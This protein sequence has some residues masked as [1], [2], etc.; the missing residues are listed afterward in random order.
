MYFLPPDDI[1]SYLSVRSKCQ[2][3]DV[4]P[5]QPHKGGRDEKD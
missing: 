1:P 4:V 3:R 2:K 5:E